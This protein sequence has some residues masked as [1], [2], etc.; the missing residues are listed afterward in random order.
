MIRQLSNPVAADA[1][2]PLRVD[3]AF[4]RRGLGLGLL[5]CALGL[6]V[7]GLVLA[8][9]PRAGLGLVAVALLPLH[10]GAAGGVLLELMRTTP[11]RAWPRRCGFGRPVGSSLLRVGLATLWILAL[12]SLVHGATAALW[13]WLGAPATPPTTLFAA[14]ATASGVGAVGAAAALILWVPLVEEV[15][16]RLLLTDA[17][18][19][20]GAAR[21]G[22]GSALVFA[23]A[24]GVPAHVPGL[25]LLGLILQDL[26]HRHG[27]LWAPILAHAFYNAV[28][29]AW[30]LLRSSPT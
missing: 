16:F 30:W 23:L 5:G 13:F 9:G 8:G 11:W 10:L 3:P 4:N 25:L 26:R 28:S 6:I 15:L 1:A 19:V 14:L 21:P 22:V 17:L 12:V 24:H 18:A 7:Q 29:L 27:G 2:V 20:A